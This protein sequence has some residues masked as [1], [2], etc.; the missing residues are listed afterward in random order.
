M[1]IH[2]LSLVALEAP[3]TITEI[4]K[5][6]MSDS[7]LSLVIKKLE[8]G[9][10]PTTADWKR[11]PLCCYQQI[12]PQ[13]LLHETIL[14]CKMRSPTMAAEKLF[15]VVPGSLC[16][17]FLTTAHD[18]A[19]H[20]GSDHTLSQLSQ[21]AYWVGMAKDVICHC[22]HCSKCQFNKSLPAHTAPLQPII[23]SRPWEL[24][25]VDILKVPQSAQGNQ[26]IL[27]VQNYFSKWPFVQAMPDQKA[28]RIV[29]SLCDQVFTLV[30]SPQRLHSD[31]GQNFESYILAELCKAF[32]VTKS[33]TTPYH[34]MGD[35]LVERMNRSLLNLLRIFSQKGDWE[36]D[37]QVLLFVYR[38]SKHSSTGLSPY[39]I[40]FGYNP[41]SPHFPHLQTTTILDPG[42]YSSQLRNKLL[43][44]RELV[45]ANIV[46]SAGQQQQYY[47][48]SR[49]PQLR[50]GQKILLSNTMRGKLDPRWTGPWVVQNY[51][52]PTTLRIKIM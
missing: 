1:L 42:E 40:L 18:K 6:Q 23:A 46:R 36:Q 9:D 28:E 27:V 16:K 43:E 17:Q 10:A 19:G 2:S 38:T 3:L 47:K 22:S 32:Q 35:G 50:E 41:P 48:S 5:A 44:I 15:I 13:L 14:C 51:H 8:D 20:Q 7:T 25:A 49:P 31:Q 37:L 12:W 45:D 11:F 30:R 21:T 34:P 29:K 26:Y 4:Y 33:H 39:E 52:N 24:V